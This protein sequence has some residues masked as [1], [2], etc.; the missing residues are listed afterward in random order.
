MGIQI[1][2]VPGL[3]KTALDVTATKVNTM[4]DQGK[5]CIISFNEMSLKSHVFYQ[6]NTDELVGLEDFGNGIKTDRLATSAIMFMA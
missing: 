4:S 3:T 6:S 2:N 1:P 5:K